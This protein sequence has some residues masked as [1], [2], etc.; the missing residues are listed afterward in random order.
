VELLAPLGEAYV[1]AVETHDIDD[2]YEY[3]SEGVIV[4]WRIVLDAP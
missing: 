1:W 3:Q 4:C 2:S